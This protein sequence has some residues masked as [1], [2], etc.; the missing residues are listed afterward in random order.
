MHASRVYDRARQTI[1]ADC[2]SHSFDT[3]A[4][5]LM[6]FFDIVVFYLGLLFSAWKNI[7]FYLY[8]GDNCA[9]PDHLIFS[10]N[11]SRMILSKPID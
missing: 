5:N 6:P 8:R 1:Y 3:L 4:I 9:S 10:Y 2:L 7:S 11:A